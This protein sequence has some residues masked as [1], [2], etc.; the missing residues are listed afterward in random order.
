RVQELTEK[1]RL[2][3]YYK[4]DIEVVVDRLVAKRDIRRRVADSVETALQLA[5]GLVSVAVEQHDGTEEV[6][7]FS[8][9]LACTYDGISFEELAP[10]NFSFNS[11][12]GACTTC[13][14][15]G[16]YLQVDPELIVPDPDLS[17][18]E[19]AVATWSVR[20]GYS[21]RLLAAVAEAHGF[22]TQVP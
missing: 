10:R 8:Q 6:V 2:D 12:Y 16:V 9:K 3:R 11:P 18:E 19:G 20:D 21:D 7:T 22:S 14:G 17:I 4:H 15:L 1:I 5:E 13:D